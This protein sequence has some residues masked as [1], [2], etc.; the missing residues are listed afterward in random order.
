MWH[1]RLGH[2]HKDGV[3][4]TIGYEDDLKEVCET[5]AL[6]KQSSKPVPKETQSKSQKPLELVYLD[7]VGPFEVPSLSGS[8]YV[9]TF[10]DE[11][12]KHSIVKFMSKKS[13][14][15][16]KFKEY[17]AEYGTPQRLRTDN[18]TEYT[19]MQ[20][21]DYCRDSKI[22]QEFT[23]PETPQQ[24]GVAKRFNRTLVEMGRSLLI[25]AKLP[26]RYWGRALSTAS[27]I[28]NITLNLATAIKERVPLNSSPENRQGAT[29][30]EFLA[31]RH[32][33]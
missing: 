31:A 28:R 5:C 18:G 8:R 21:K 14:T 16:E 6:G 26:K 1:Q 2:L 27:H 24:N 7:I 23:V 4:R 9:I 11:Y 3:K 19:S 33:L 13:Q 30:Y 25:Q 22:K 15:F 10:I 20:F 17:V 29:I 12:S 32:M